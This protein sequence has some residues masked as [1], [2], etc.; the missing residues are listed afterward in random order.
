M[1]FVI[2]PLK[3]VVFDLTEDKTLSKDPPLNKIERPLPVFAIS[4]KS[5]NNNKSQTNL[6]RNSTEP[7]VLSPISPIR[8]L[9]FLFAK[10]F[11]KKPHEKLATPSIK[12][13]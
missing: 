2:V 7:L 4:K 13:I 6:V 9:Y 1:T 10:K 5:E 11:T 8:N 12:A 3:F